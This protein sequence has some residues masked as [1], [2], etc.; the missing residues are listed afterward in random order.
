V[1]AD[2]RQSRRGGGA[3]RLRRA[4]QADPS[5]ERRARALPMQ[6]GAAGCGW[7]RGAPGAVSGQLAGKALGAGVI[8][9]IDCLVAAQAHGRD[10]GL[11]EDGQRPEARRHAAAGE[12]HVRREGGKHAI[13]AGVVVADDG[14]Q[15]GDR[16][17]H[18]AHGVRGRGHGD[19]GRRGARM[20]GSTGPEALRATGG[21]KPLQCCATCGP[22]HARP[23]RLPRALRRA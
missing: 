10:G 7:A 15:A 16:L 5:P 9:K 17:A 2:D 4:W 20:E 12:V 22:P 18:G 14:R 23:Q 3:V 6:A 13:M 8:E 1:R 21:C 19:Q 11:P